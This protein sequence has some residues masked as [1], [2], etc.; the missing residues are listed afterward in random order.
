MTDEPRAIHRAGRPDWVALGLAFLLAAML[1]FN[2]VMLIA[3]L[4]GKL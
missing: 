4:V 1:A 2:T 3:N